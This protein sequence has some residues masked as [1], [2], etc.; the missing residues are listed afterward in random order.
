MLYI[1]E[2]VQVYLNNKTSMMDAKSLAAANS[3]TG[4]PG[5]SNVMTN[6]NLNGAG[7]LFG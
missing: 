3:S 6:S 2:G 1:I 7:S 5:S 4:L